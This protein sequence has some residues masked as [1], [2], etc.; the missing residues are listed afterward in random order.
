MAQL[1]MEVVESPFLE[2]PQSR[3]D[4]ARGDVGGGR[5]EGFSNL[6]DSVIR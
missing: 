1:P 4:V 6:N 3:G 2:A 5:V